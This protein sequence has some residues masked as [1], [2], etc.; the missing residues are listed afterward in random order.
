MTKSVSMTCDWCTKREDFT[1][2]DA[3][4]EAAE[5]GWFVLITPE[6]ERCYCSTDCLVSDL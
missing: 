3:G 2:D 6:Q 1:G 4:V 5:A